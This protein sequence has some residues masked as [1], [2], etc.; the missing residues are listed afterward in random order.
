MT[1]TIVHA[2]LRLRRAEPADVDF[3]AALASD[4]EIEPFVAAISPRTHDQLLPEVQ[5]SLAEPEAFG[6]LVV[7]VSD[8]GLWR[9]AGALAYE[10]FNRRSRI[11]SVHAVMIAPAFRGRGLAEQATRLATRYLIRERGYHRVQL[12]VYGFNER[13]QR[14]FE[15]AGFMREGVRRRAYWRHGEWQDGVLFGLLEE[16]LDDGDTEPG[17][18]AGRKESEGHA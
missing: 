18:P 3:L 5:R 4:E 1:E 7:E 8:G 10:A 6:R 16:E 17:T 14:V 15:R 9:L 11:V 13:A 2:E 12:E